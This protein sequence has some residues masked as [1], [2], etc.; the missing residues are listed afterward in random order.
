MQAERHPRHRDEHGEQNQQHHEE[1]EPGGGDDR[2]TDGMQGVARWKAEFIQRGCPAITSG[3]ARKGRGL[4][5]CSFSVRYISHAAKP[6]TSICGAATAPRVPP[7]V[8]SAIIRTR[9]SRCQAPADAKKR[10]CHI[11]YPR[12]VVATLLNALQVPVAPVQLERARHFLRTPI[13][14]LAAVDAVD[15]A[16]SRR[17]RIRSNR[18][19]SDAAVRHLLGTPGTRRVLDGHAAS[20]LV[21]AVRARQRGFESNDRVAANRMPQRRYS[22]I[23]SRPRWMRLLTASR[24]RRRKWAISV[25]EYSWKSRST[26]ASRYLSGND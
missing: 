4:R 11:G 10:A 12:T 25:M 9:T 5:V 19:H 18:R 6:V 2:E 21:L 1:G 8:A 20:L 26:I 23:I 24:V 3:C 13:H 22:R 14:P 15:K 16:P 7:K 17:N